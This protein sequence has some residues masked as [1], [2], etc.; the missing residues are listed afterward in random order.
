[1]VLIMCKVADI[2]NAHVD[3]PALACPLQYAAFEICWKDFRDKRKNIE[4][5]EVILLLL[6][7]ISILI[8][9]M[10]G[11]YLDNVRLA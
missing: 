6:A 7:Q 11:I 9:F 2:V 10:E 3:Q 4:L 8:S 5:H 1:M